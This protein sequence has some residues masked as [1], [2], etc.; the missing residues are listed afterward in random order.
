MNN[1]ERLHAMT[2]SAVQKLHSWPKRALFWLKRCIEEMTALLA[3]VT[4]IILCRLATSAKQCWDPC[5]CPPTNSTNYWKCISNFLLS[6]L[7]NRQCLFWQAN[8][9]TWSNPGTQVGPQNKDFGAV[10]QTDLTIVWFLLWRRLLLYRS[11]TM[12]IILY[13]E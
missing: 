2:Y 10:L 11:K 6:W 1:N 13:E 7:S 4:D 8:H 9:C 5:S 12:N 3:S